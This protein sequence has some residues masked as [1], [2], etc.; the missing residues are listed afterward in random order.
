MTAAVP[1]GL[2]VGGLAAATP[3]VSRTA[4]TRLFNAAGFVPLG[5]SA[6]RVSGP[7]NPGPN[8]WANRSYARRVVSL[9]GFP[10]ASLNP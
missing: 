8:P 4:T 9:V 3:G 5:N 1:D 10:P 6:A 2:S 7:L